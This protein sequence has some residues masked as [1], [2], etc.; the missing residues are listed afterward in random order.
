MIIPKRIKKCPM[1]NLFN[2]YPALIKQAGV[3]L[4]E[5]LG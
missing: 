2:L 5:N 1:G 4:V 3:C